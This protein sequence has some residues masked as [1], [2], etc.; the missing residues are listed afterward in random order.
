MHKKIFYATI[1]TITFIFL[2]GRTKVTSNNTIQE[3][4]EASTITVNDSTDY[5]NGR[6]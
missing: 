2:T 5:V 3:N 6:P 4:S 1:I